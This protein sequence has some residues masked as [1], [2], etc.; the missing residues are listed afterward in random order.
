MQSNLTI[1]QPEFDV[2]GHAYSWGFGMPAPRNGCEVRDRNGEIEF[3]AHHATE[4]FGQIS[5][6]H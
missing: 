4:V 1:S 6:V 5:F 2:P 3:R